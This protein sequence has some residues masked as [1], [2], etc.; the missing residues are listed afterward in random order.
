[1]QLPH[2][3]SLN[4]SSIARFLGI[5]ALGLVITNAATTT[6]LTWND[7][8]YRS[9]L[10]L[11]I[12][13]ENNIP[14]FFSSFLLLFI[15][16]LLAFITM[17]E[18]NITP[19]SVLY[20]K[21]L[22]WGFLFMAID[23]TAS[24]HE[25]LILPTRKLLGE[26]SLG[27]FYFSWVIPALLLIVVFALFFWQ[28][29]LHLPHKI[30]SISLI[31]AILYLGGCIGFEMIGGY[32]AELHGSENLIYC[33]IVSIEESLEM[34]GA[35]VFSWGLMRHIADNYGKVEFQFDRVRVNAKSNVD[36]V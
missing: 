13:R 4:P 9:L 12:D 30:R 33:L 22:S 31:A 11:D 15:A 7:R 35:I 28:F 21:I 23:E 5:T 3:I 32:F 14:A 10:I 29:W 2:Q 19:D 6:Y 36:R 26:G 27:I 24:V 20:W 18:K 1:M 17:L 8:T 34:M 25:R 16:L